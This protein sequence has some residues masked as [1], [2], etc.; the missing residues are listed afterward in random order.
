MKRLPLPLLLCLLAS[1]AVAAAPAKGNDGIAFFESK[2]R[3]V[4]VK[5]CYSCH[6]D[7]ARKNKKLKGSLLLDSR[8]GVFAGG[9]TGP[10]V[11]PG[12]SKES[13]LVQAVRH[14]KTKMPPKEMLPP[15][16]IADL[17]KWVDMGAPDPRDSTAL[18]GKRVIDIEAAKKLWA[19]R[20]LGRVA[21]PEVKNAAWVRTPVDR[22]VLARLEERGL[23]PAPALD[24]VRLLRRVTF[25][26]VGLPPTPEEIDAFVK[27]TSPD[28]YPKVVRRLLK[29]ERHG[30]RWARHWLDLS[31]FA[32]SGGYEFDK[33]RPGAYQFRD[34]VIKALNDGMPYDE[35]VRLQLAGDHL[36]PDDLSAA[37]ATGFLVAGPYPGQTTAKTLEPIR[38][39]HLDDMVSTTGTA[40]LGL[41]VGCARCHEH[42]Y[43]P[44]PQQDYYQLVATLGRTDSAERKIDPTPEKTRQAKAVFDKAHAPLLAARDRFEKDELP[45]RLAKWRAEEAKRPAPDWLILDPV[46]TPGLTKVAKQADGSSL[47]ADGGETFTFVAHT[48]QK[49]V[50]GIRLDALPDA[51]L[52]KS[53][54]GKA[55]D[56]NFRL[57]EMTLNAAPLA[58]AKAKPVVVKLK[59]AGATFE[60]PGFALGGKAGWSVG[61]AAGKAHAGFFAAE[62]PVG[63]DGGTALTVT[64]KFA[65]G[66]ALGRFRLS[67]STA[68]P[69][70]LAGEPKPQHGREALAM[71]DPSKGKIDP[72]Q[73]DHLLRWFRAVDARTN[74]VLA[75]VEK[76]A[77][78]E[79]KPQLVPVFAATSG[80]GGDVHYLI[81]GEMDRK[82]GVATPGFLQ[83][84]TATPGGQRRWLTTT[85]GGKPAPVPPR[86]ALANWI[87]DDAHGAG[88]LLARV[89][90][91][92]MWQYHFGK[93]LVRTPNDFGA[94][95]E[96]PTHPELLDWLASE[97][98]RGGWKL[99]P[100]H[101]ILLT[102]AAYT[103]SGE[104]GPVTR[105]SD[106]DN[107]L[108]G[109]VPSRRLEAEVIR[110][111]L[112]AVGGALEQKL[113]GPGSLDEN[114]PR[115]SIYLTNKRSQ[116]I[117]LLQAFDAPEGIQAVGQRQSTTATT[118]A[119][120]M[121]NSP[122]VRQSADKLAARVRPKDASGLPTAVE[123][124]YLLALGRRPSAAERDRMLA[125]IA[126][127]PAKDQ[128]L[129]DFCQVLLC[130]NEFIYVD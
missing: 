101:E 116:L 6:S 90:V 65:K 26:L 71:I 8:E 33:D 112:L 77:L 81:R 113:Y 63:F 99:G 39:D 84:L 123:N 107:L 22:F 29:S 30:E 44:I 93:G 110:D 56:G 78:S 20:P 98:I 41:S 21:P 55:G 117:P 40:L 57:M 79:P 76:H 32:E 35:F 16:V 14:E 43:D 104:A 1:P 36:K 102:S 126:R 130:L 17:A 127:Q 34:F 27:D 129:A 48:F 53:G 128:A 3:P 49:G 54:P 38:Y 67:I 52:P 28:A 10:A 108:W 97:L 25:D 91:N 47:V 122:L 125:F 115:R 120:T 4:L 124:A 111:S 114:S 70:K 75:A 7:E 89:I 83:A 119:L 42:K 15:E 121:M 13:L 100:I 106:P 82:N 73:R 66:H 37:A 23:M 92:R 72:K 19:F 105:K 11:V 85:S 2:V 61:G 95:G 5:H 88:H 74:E 64:L 45:A 18:P 80:R 68:K 94:Q 58:D 12:K 118:Q 86:V 50:T 60:Q 62:T 24:R 87:T 69:A 96:P 51:S 103:Q 31:R 9:D 59:P 109:R 46:S